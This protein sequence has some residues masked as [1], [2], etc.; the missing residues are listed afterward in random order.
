MRITNF[1]FSDQLFDLLKIRIKTAVKSYHQFNT[2]FFNCLQGPF[3]YFKGEV[4]RLFTEYMLTCF[5]SINDIF[6][7]CVSRGTNNH[8]FNVRMIDDIQIIGED[9]GYSECFGCFL[10]TLNINIGNSN[11][12]CLRNTLNQCS[13]MNLANSSGANNSCLLYTSDAADE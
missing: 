1:P 3:N 10:C 13:N 9:R 6:G 4:N 12:F 5:C 2:R 7:M 11:Y 8:C